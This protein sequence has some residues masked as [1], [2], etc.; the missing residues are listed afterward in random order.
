MNRAQDIIQLFEAF[1]DTRKAFMVFITPE[2]DY[3]KVK[4]ADDHL[5]N[6][7]LQ[8]PPVYMTPQKFFEVIPH[9]ELTKATFMNAL[10]RGDTYGI[11]VDQNVI[12]HLARK[13]EPTDPQTYQHTLNRQVPSTP[14]FNRYGTMGGQV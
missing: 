1:E 2:Q 4:F 14:T 10:E 8:F 6:A 13:G 5:G 9:N 7:D 11:Y 3:V 12:K